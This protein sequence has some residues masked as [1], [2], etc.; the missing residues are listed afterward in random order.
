MTSVAGI[1]AVTVR[2]AEII[3]QFSKTTTGTKIPSVKAVNPQQQQ[4][5]QYT[6]T[7]MAMLMILK[8]WYEDDINSTAKRVLRTG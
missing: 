8:L 7:V 6:E 2:S 3:G 5:Q 4:Q 1:Y